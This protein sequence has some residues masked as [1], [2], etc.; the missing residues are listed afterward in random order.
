MCR[1]LCRTGRFKG[2]TLT[3]E[4]TTDDGTFAVPKHVGGLLKS[5]VCLC[6]CIYIY[7]YTHIY[8]YIYIYCSI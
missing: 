3:S 7:I 8:I 4:R 5:G 1:A 6:V 2:F